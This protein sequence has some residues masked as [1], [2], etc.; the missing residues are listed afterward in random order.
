VGRWRYLAS[1]LCFFL[2]AVGIILPLAML[3]IGSFMRLYG[4]FSVASPYTA[5]HWISALRDPLFLGSLKNSFLIGVGV[6]TLGVMVYAL[7][8]YAIVRSRIPGRRIVGMLAWLPWAVPGILLGI[9][10]LWLMLVFPGFS[11]L[12]GTLA[13][14]IL[15]LVIKEM[16]IGI[17]MM[18]TAFSQVSE[19]LEEASRVSGASW[20]TTFRRVSLPLIAPTLVSIF[21]LVFIAA[22]RD[23]STTIL[24]VSASTR[25]LSILMMEFSR[26]GQLEI[27]SIL[28]V[29]VSALAIGVALIARRLGLQLEEE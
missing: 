28:G 6:S 27:A 26:G 2:I 22:L 18:K 20:A 1:A 9:A 13:P 7:I 10:F 14:L 8:G 5:T 29:I 15:V 25:P 4:F 19:E 24:L 16:P 11:L 23:I 3:I 21:V 12:Y 17:H